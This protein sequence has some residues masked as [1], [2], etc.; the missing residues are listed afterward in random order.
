LI[1]RDI[2]EKQKF[3]ATVEEVTDSLEKMR[4]NYSDPKILAELDRDEFKNDLS[5]RIVTQKAVDWLCDQAK[6]KK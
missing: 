5:N 1:I 4:M 6:Q 3:T 2:I